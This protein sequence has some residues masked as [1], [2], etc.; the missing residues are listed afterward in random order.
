MSVALRERDV[1]NGSFST[2]VKLMPWTVGGFSTPARSRMVAE[3]SIEDTSESVR[4][5]A[6]SGPVMISGVLIPLS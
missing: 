2:L 6:T 3:K 5:F 1:A 4:P